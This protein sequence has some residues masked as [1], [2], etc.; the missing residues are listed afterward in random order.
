M[1]FTV[2]LTLTA[3]LL[4]LYGLKV[5][6]ASEKR[7]YRL[8]SESANAQRVAMDERK[9]STFQ[10][11]DIIANALG[12]DGNIT[13]DNGVS[14][15]LQ[16]LA[17]ESVFENVAIADLNGKLLYQNGTQSD[18]S[19]RSYFK[20]AVRGELTTQYL[21]NGRMSGNSVFVFAA[22]IYAD[23]KVIG[24]IIGTRNLDEI[25]NIIDNENI[26]GY[27]FLCYYDGEIIAVPPDENQGI[28]AGGKLD[29]YFKQSG[30]GI[31]ENKVL[32]YSYGG[33]TYYGTYIASGL[34]D[35]FIFSIAARDYASNLA[36]LYSKTGII[37][38]LLIP[39]LTFIVSA[40]III[41]LKKRIEIAKTNEIER[42]NKLKEYH[43]FQTKRSPDHTG[44]LSSA[45]MN[46][47]KN[48]CQN[49]T[50]M[51]KELMQ[52]K[53]N[54][55]IDEI[56]DAVVAHIHPAD[57]ERYDECI[58]RSAFICEAKK[59]KTTLQNDFLF[60]GN[61]GRYIWIRIIVDIM[62]NPITDDYEAIVSAVDVNN[63]KRLEQIGKKLIDESLVA[64][65]LIDA[66]SGY[67][68][69]VK[70]IRGYSEM[71]SIY[72]SRHFEY[73]KVAEAVFEN[74]M[75]EYDFKYI[76]NG[77]KLET[78]KEKLKNSPFWSVTVHIT[79]TEKSDDVGYY[80]IKYSYLD[81]RKESIVVSCENITDILASKLDI[82]TGLYN[83]A[84]FHERIAEWIRENPNRK[85]R[86]YRYN[87]DGFSDINGIYGYKAG[88][89]LLRDIGRFMRSQDTA[90][91]FSAHLNADHFACF[92]SD[93]YMSAEEYYNRFLDAFSDYEIHY[94][95]SMHIGV[96]DLCEENCTSYTMSYKALLA[97][98]SIKYDQ[99]KHIAYYEKGLMQATK[100][101]RELIGDVENAVRNND[102]EL[103]LQPQFSYSGA[104][105]GAEALVRWRHPQKGLIKPFDFVPLLEKSK[106]ITLVDKYIWNKSCEFAKRLADMGIC[107]PISVN[108]SRIDI[109]NCDICCCI[110][111]MTKKH[112]INPKLIN[113]EITESAYLTE[114]EELKRTVSELKNCG[115]TVEMDD[116]GSGYSSLNILLD[117]D[118]DT[119][120]LDRKLI[121]QVESGNEKGRDIVRTVVKMA[122]VLNM[123]V[124][125]E[126]IESKEQADFLNTL[127]NIGMQGYYYSKPMP[128]EKFEE[129]LKTKQIGEI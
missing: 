69:G 126:G 70:A 117:L 66:K 100:N 64:M 81:S 116:F 112:E 114:S 103:W 58:S 51:I 62:K 36:G 2:L 15:R 96:Y 17:K 7:V 34:D 35:I 20:D 125:A 32:S 50:N 115:F 88:N 107:I 63:A 48:I 72:R 91:S 113:I 5:G 78:I 57:R 9:K 39:V 80:T 53:D 120:K 16:N 4:W 128:C 37:L 23:G 54:C 13:S 86:I 124:I 111:D 49:S 95:L 79:K 87:L 42:E 110:S 99:S 105:I 22:P 106:Q 41:R 6:E 11:L 29:E 25:V 123:S 93:K 127:G 19:D 92:C 45:G 60:Y 47:T 119:L 18:C 121:S 77:I 46:L 71:K 24:A 27:N 38:A 118:I 3:L 85:F 56:C 65:G 68:F 101:E 14:Q 90:D 67:I 97:L 61:N 73:E 129:F 74:Y 33:D 89:K 82:E 55:S 84:G 98:Q 122:R 44:V 8:L 30:G 43:D 31:E 104:V 21:N 52:G 28:T 102:F 1:P 76:R 40:I 10:Q 83:S 12:W 26:H 108:V 59:G 75:S 109:Q 94:P